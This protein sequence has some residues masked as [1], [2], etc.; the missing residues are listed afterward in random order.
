[1]RI[2]S[3]IETEEFIG[4]TRED[5]CNLESRNWIAKLIYDNWT[6]F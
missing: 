1:M 5:G 2:D 6:V 4:S 3:F